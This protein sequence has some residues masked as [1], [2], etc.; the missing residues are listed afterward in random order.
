MIKRWRTTEAVLE[1]ARLALPQP[2]RETRVEFDQA[3][4]EYQEY[5]SHNELGLAFDALKGAAELVPSRGSVWKD[6]IRAAEFMELND[7]IPDLERR[8][9]AAASLNEEAVK[10][11]EVEID[12][13]QIHDWASFHSTFA[14]ALGFPD[15]YGRNM[16]AWIDC[17]TALDDPDAGMSK[18]HAPKGGIV[19]LKVVNAEDFAKRCPEQFGALNECSAFV[20]WRRR[21]QGHPP[22]LALSYHQ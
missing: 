7:Q 20:N 12:A 6:L 3:I 22:V 18:V 8:F 13:A 16:N 11:E 14:A 10:F 17:M 2:K 4:A 5:L 21:E 9:E 15:F 19:L 1:R